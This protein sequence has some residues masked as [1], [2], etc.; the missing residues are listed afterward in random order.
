MIFKGP[1]AKIVNHHHHNHFHR[2]KRS[3]NPH[4]RRSLV[5]VNLDIGPIYIPKAQLSP[6]NNPE[7]TCSLDLLDFEQ[8]VVIQHYELRKP[9]DDVL[10]SLKNSHKGDYAAGVRPTHPNYIREGNSSS[11]LNLSFSTLFYYLAF[12]SLSSLFLL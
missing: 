4:Q 1:T 10:E 3:N 5:Q 9:I 2:S 12:L 11:K 6:S 8:N 7:L